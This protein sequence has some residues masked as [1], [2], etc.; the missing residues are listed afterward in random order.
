MAI[1]GG[2]DPPHTT[3]TYAEF[4]LLFGG[5]FVQSVRGISNYGMNAIIRLLFDPVEAVR[6]DQSRLTES[7]WFTPGL[8]GG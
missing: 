4:C 5:V 8:Q 2:W 3:F 7:H 6:V 1:E